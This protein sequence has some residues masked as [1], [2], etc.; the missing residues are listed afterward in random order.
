MIPQKLAVVAHEDDQRVLSLPR[1]IKHVQDVLE[2]VI[3][4]LNHGIITGREVIGAIAMDVMG[5]RV[6]ARQKRGPAG[7]ADRALS[8]GAG[9]SH[10]L[11]AEGVEIRGMDVRVAQCVNGVIPLL[12]A[13]IPQNVWSLVSRRD[14]SFLNRILGFMLIPELNPVH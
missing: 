12:V 13:A 7:R 10:P 11:L 6:A 9:K 3:N 8:I 1:F 14:I 4:Q 2:L 5:A